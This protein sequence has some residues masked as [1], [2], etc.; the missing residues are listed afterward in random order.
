MP[1]LDGFQMSSMLRQLQPYYIL[2]PFVIV[3]LT[4][5]DSRSDWIQQKVRH[6]GIDLIFEKPV[7]KN[8]MKKILQE[9]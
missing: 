2:S 7:D 5:Y 1:I 3:G 4:S 6:H 8:L 9:S